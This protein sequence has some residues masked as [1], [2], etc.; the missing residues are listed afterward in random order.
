MMGEAP[1]PQLTRALTDVGPRGIAGALA[2]HGDERS[3]EHQ[4][5][6][7]EDN[8]ELRHG[9]EEEHSSE[10]YL[11]MLQNVCDRLRR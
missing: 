5:G 1:R 8:W 9:Y 4:N 11:S 10:E 7:R 3:I 6:R 2:D